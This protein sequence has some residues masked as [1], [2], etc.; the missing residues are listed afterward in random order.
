MECEFDDSNSKLSNNALEKIYKEID[1]L[2]E[3]NRTDG[4]S[5]VWPIECETILLIHLFVGLTVPLH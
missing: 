3:F 2:V 1:H 4:L 5:Q